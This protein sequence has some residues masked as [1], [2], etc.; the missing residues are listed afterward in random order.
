MPT[1]SLSCSQETIDKIKESFKEYQRT[2]K[3]PYIVF[4]AKAENCI[5]SIY[6]SDKVV[7]QGK[8]AHIYASAFDP[9]ILEEEMAESD[10]FPQAGSD[11]VG[12][13]DY[14]G[15]VCVCA[16]LLDVE[17]INLIKKYK[18]QDSKQCTDEQICEIAPHLMQAIPYSLLILDNKK[19]NE[20]H[21]FNNMNQ[22]KAILHNQAYVH[23]KK[24]YG[25]LPSLCVV[26][27]FTPFENYYRYLKNQPSVITNLH[28]E[29]KAENKYPAVACASII[30][31]Y[32]FLKQWEKME[33]KY[34]MSFTKGA[35]SKCD[36]DGFYF[37]KR[38]GWQKL[39]E[40]AK[41]HFK[42]TDKITELL[43]TE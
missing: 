3:N 38:Y 18:I 28:F 5:I 13:G 35:S 34:E 17:N 1:Y 15:C 8:D 30:A 40:V 37:V 42:N 19:Y 41:I 25:K 9:S 4:E 22:I 11:E 20:I 36:E 6:T 26:D 2:T 24:K 29:T 12:T 14:F 39:N 32:A 43:N 7:F 10:V 31:R 16:C 27:Q 33:E 23:L 21:P